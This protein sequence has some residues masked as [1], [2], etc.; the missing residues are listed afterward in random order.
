MDLAEIGLK[1]DSSQIK[2]ADKAL[3][4]FASSAKN[5]GRSADQFSGAETKAV[6]ATDRLK[7]SVTALNTPLTMLKATLGGVVA[8][9]GLRFLQQAADGYT[10]FSNRL[11]I[12][13]LEGQAFTE[14]EDRLF[15]A[16]NRNGQAIGSVGQLYQKAAQAGRDLGAT[17]EDL[18]QF[19]DGVTAALKVNGGSAESASG[20]LLQLGQALGGGT[21]RAEEFNSILEGAPTIAQ[22]AAEGFYGA[23]GSVSAL[24]NE[25]IA[26]NVSSKE[27]F[28][29]FL[30]GA[31]DMEARA[32]SLGL[33]IGASFTVLT[34]GIVRF[35]G[36]LDAVTGASSFVAAGIA[37]I[38]LGLSYLAQ[39]LD[40]I[41]EL[42]TPLLPALVGVFG[43]YVLGL[44]LQLTAVGVMG[45]YGAISSLFLLIVANPISVFVGAIV[46]L[47][48]Y[49]IDWQQSIS[50]LIKLWGAFV[51]A[52][53]SFWGNEAGAQRGIEIVLSADRATEELL[54]TGEQVKAKII[55]GMGI[56]GN[57]AAAKIANGMAAGGANAAN[58]IRGA[59]AAGVQSAAASA[60]AIYENLNGVPQ[61]I[62][63]AIQ[64]GADYMKNE[65]TGEIT[66]ASTQGGKNI[67][68]EMTLGGISAGSS[69]GS[70]MQSAGTSVGNNLF[71]TLAKVGDVWVSS[72]QKYIGSLI[73]QQI[74]AQTALMRAQA[75]QYE[76][77]A[78]LLRAQTNELGRRFKD[79]GG[80]GGGGSGAFSGSGGGGRFNFN[81]QPFSWQHEDGEG[82]GGSMRG[83]KFWSVAGGSGFARGGEF[84]VP[85]SGGTDSK[86]V[87][88]AAT[89]GERVTVQTP[90]QQG[91][92][93]NKPTVELTNVNVFDPQNLVAALN[94][95]SGRQTLINWAKANKEELNAVLGVYSS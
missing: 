82:S 94:T 92:N 43:P 91:Q 64:A 7:A 25:V 68:H 59:A 24:R 28:E 15:E 56:G 39:N 13:G 6:K 80:S 81:S 86:G 95:Q 29:N 66:K 62:K 30:K 79:T 71:E 14:V 54:A 2:A 4:E 12:A 23:G 3:D 65:V 61:Q 31:A 46:V 34:N 73:Q 72:I 50:G 42:I 55:E 51:Y 9:L 45:L 36:A 38:G 40:M 26:G 74:Q 17:Q 47:L 37:N 19:V 10:E 41:F 18:L 69:I 53:N 70:A 58:Q 90:T 16:A 22:A 77:Q 67:G 52:W 78:N 88:F 35:I 85:G 63:G 20:A 87:A 33:T 5:A 8:G 89:P 93:D 11:K 83:V 60:K 44:I 21:V 48:G 76:A 49:M 1:A 75:Q 84:T 32:N 57:D 27:F